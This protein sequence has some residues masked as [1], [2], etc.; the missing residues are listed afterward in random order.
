MR[1][2]RHSQEGGVRGGAGTRV[3]R[4]RLYPD[5]DSKARQLIGM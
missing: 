4:R 3:A 2:G 1:V 5:R